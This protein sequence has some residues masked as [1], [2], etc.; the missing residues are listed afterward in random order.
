MNFTLVL[1]FDTINNV[2]KCA[3]YM[4]S[5]TAALKITYPYLDLDQ[6][7]LLKAPVTITPSTFLFYRTAMCF[8][9]K[10]IISV[11]EFRVLV[12]EAIGEA[13]GLNQ[14]LIQH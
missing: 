10:R 7:Y 5:N 9:S 3:Q 13:S 12:N 1:E 14:R 8:C 4:N 11:S 2:S 6:N